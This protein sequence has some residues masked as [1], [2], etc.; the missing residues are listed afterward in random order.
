MPTAP[1]F[2]NV[3]IELALL[4]FPRKAY[5][6]F[7]IRP[8]MTNPNTMASAVKG[9]LVGATSFLGKLSSSVTV[10]GVKVSYGTD[11]GED[12]VGFDVGNVAG[13]AAGGTV[14]PNVALLVHKRTLRGGR[15][16]RGRL[17]IPWI[18]LETNVDN[19]GTVDTTTL[20]A[21][22]TAMDNWR[23]ALATADVPMYLL[24]DPG[25]TVSGPPDQ[26]L[27]LEVDRTV[28]TQKRRLGR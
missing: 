10:T 18:L 4:G 23:A 11:G 27:N 15:R 2:G 21:T 17:F 7:G 19:A 22:Q 6:T 28:A 16:G 13:T 14:T 20:T 9:S 24:H 8:T 12:L 5:I 1:G 25:K 26:V 3:S